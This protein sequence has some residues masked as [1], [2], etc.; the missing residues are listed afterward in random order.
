MFDPTFGR[1]SENFTKSLSSN[2][3]SPIGPWQQVSLDRLLEH[4]DMKNGSSVSITEASMKD[5]WELGSPQFRDFQQT[6]PQKMSPI[7]ISSLLS[8]SPV[9]QNSMA[10]PI[11]T[12]APTVNQKSPYLLPAV[13]NHIFEPEQDPHPIIYDKPVQDFNPT[14][15]RRGNLTKP[16]NFPYSNQASTNFAPPMLQIATDDPYSQQ[17][18]QQNIGSRARIPQINTAYVA[19]INHGMNYNG[20]SGPPILLPP[21][22]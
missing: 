15:R 8:S 6:Y 14:V 2:E 20:V 1:T 13:D 11:P 12:T 17:H 21:A 10:N 22:L 7:D 5:I 9:H 16:N 19:C 18:K 3:I 4:H